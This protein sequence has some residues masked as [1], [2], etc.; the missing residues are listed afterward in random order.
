[1]LSERGVVWIAIVIV[2]TFFWGATYSLYE[3]L[4][5]LLEQL[6]SVPQ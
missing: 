4:P 5:V 2:L 3:R 1:M 6:N